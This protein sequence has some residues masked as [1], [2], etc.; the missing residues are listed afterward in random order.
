MAGAGGAAFKFVKPNSRPQAT[1]IQ[2]AA[3]WGVAAFTTAV[4]IVQGFPSQG[5]RQKHDQVGL[6]DSEME[7]Q[8]QLQQHLTWSQMITRS[9][10]ELK[11]A[12]ETLEAEK[13]T[14]AA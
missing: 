12:L 8:P 14:M 7:Q 13:K 9:S 4:W 11:K 10:A 6:R 2:A 3:A 5:D 1:D